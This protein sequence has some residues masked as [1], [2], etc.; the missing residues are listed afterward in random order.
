MA[1]C[2]RSARLLVAT[3]TVLAITGSGT[4][5][6]Q[7]QLRNNVSDF[8]INSSS[9]LIPVLEEV[10]QYITN[11]SGGY[12]RLHVASGQYKL[13]GPTY[14]ALAT[15]VNVSYISI[16]GAGVDATS[17]D[18]G[19]VAG[20]A[21]LDVHFVTITNLTFANC[22][23][24]QNSTTTN[25]SQSGSESGSLSFVKFSVALYMLDC[26]H[27]HMENVNI[28]N[29]KSVGLAMFNVYGS[30]FFRGC[31]FT[32]HVPPD[33]DR[34]SGS[35]NR[36]GGGGAII[37]FSFC[38]PGDK[39]C[40]ITSPV[41]VADAS[42]EFTNCEFTSNNASSLG[43]SP[44]SIYP[45]GLQHSGFGKGGGLAVYFRG[46]AINNSVTLVNCHISFNTAESSMG[47]GLYVEFG[48]QS[49]GNSFTLTGKDDGISRMDNNG[50]LCATPS[51][52]QSS[53]Q[54]NGGGGAKIVFMYYPPD[55][56]LWP[57]YHAN[58]TDNHV[59]FRDT[60]VSSNMACYGGGVAFVSSRADPGTHQTNTVHFS[61]CS[62][63]G[64]Q[65]V[66][67]A[68]LDISVLYPDTATHG[69]LMTPLIEQCEFQQNED[70]TRSDDSIPDLAGYQFGNGAL[71]I[72]TVP[73]NFSGVNRFTRNEGT[74]LVV[75]GANVAVTTN[76]SVLFEGN[77]GRRGGGLVVLGGGALVMYPGSH[78]NFSHNQA[79]ELGGAV[80]S[81]GQFGERYNMYKEECFIRYY[82]ST[83]LPTSWNTSFSFLNNSAAGV[84]GNS[85]IHVTSL[86]PCAWPVGSSPVA[87]VR[88][89]L[90]WQGWVY[91]NQNAETM[92]SCSAYITTAPAGFN[93]SRTNLIYQVSVYPG[94][95]HPIPVR[96]KDDYG[97]IVS[98]VVYQLSSRNLT[99]VEVPDKSIYVTN[100][101]ILVYGI[102]NSAK[103]QDLFLETLGPR[104][105]S[106]MLKV[107]ILPCPPGYAPQKNESAM[108]TRCKCG[109]HL[110]LTCNIPAMT[111]HI[112]P[113]YCFSY[114]TNNSSHTG[115][116]LTRSESTQH[117]R[118][119]VVQCPA[120]VRESKPMEL[121]V[122]NGSCDIEMKFCEGIRRNGTF[123]SGCVTG[124]AVDVN[125]IHDCVKCSNNEYHYG[126]F[127]YILTNIVPIT[128]FFIVVALFK[129]SATSAPMYAF[130]FFAQIA[131]VRYFHNQF[132]WIFGLSE[133]RSYLQSLF[134]CLYAIW[135]L[136]FFVFKGVICLSP[137]LTIMYS[138][139][140]K[141]LLALYPML[142]ILLSYICI[143]LY[144][145]NVMLIV[146]L[147]KPFRACLNKF[148]QSWQ[149]RTSI[150]DAFAAFLMIS[151]TKI[152]FIT[153]SLLTPAQEYYVY[154][155]RRSEV[156]DGYVFYFDPQYHYFQGQHLLFGLVALV[157]GVVFVLAPPVFLILY[158]TRVFQRC[159]N[160][161]SSR[162]SWQ[163][164]HTFADAFQGC[165]KNRSNNNRDYR[166]FSGLYLV[167]RIVI[168][169]IYAVESLPYLQ[170]LL[171]QIICV[172]A[173][174]LFALV[175]PYKEAFY[176]KVDLTF[177][178]LFS[179]M[180]SLSFANYTYGCFNDNKVN[181]VLF[182][183]NYALGYLPLLY[184]TVYVVYLL[185]KW[186]GVI[187]VDPVVREL[188]MGKSSTSLISEDDSSSADVP[189]RLLH[190]ENYTVTPPPS[191]KSSSGTLSSPDPINEEERERVLINRG[192][193]KQRA[194]E[195]SY[196][197][198]KAQYMKNY[199]SM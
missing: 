42:F 60:Y 148:R 140:L 14:T 15:F 150:I 23:S 39:Q 194:T 169:I 103:K 157:I 165:F 145:R 47:G 183:I 177:F 135:N 176:N 2:T 28:A 80:Y 24:L 87:D 90:C 12:F 122:C 36:H 74:G 6:E 32:N 97:N 129:I 156:P 5:S 125:D 151:Y 49:Q 27:V 162:C 170:L 111:A 65:A 43:L 22:S 117:T 75:S 126:W 7:T 134:L 116:F 21:F 172:L 139:L 118:M 119:I 120:T 83:V 191:H 121:P 93:N 95:S 89:A 195:G 144:D 133:K 19:G 197:L 152:A 33:T 112:L 185:L 76:T 114:S 146:W 45:H 149:P 141:Y 11:G 196:F 106:T 161:W 167:L 30:N 55:P 61:N 50:E 10:Q 175:K 158:P 82:K 86:L 26:S 109:Y 102:P 56:H 31:Q 94:H 160:R 115:S 70:N 110:Y 100:N 181:D 51:F 64:N 187:V 40:N 54:G 99:A 84:T 136:D 72:A 142:L 25:G 171:Q 199:S 71:Y 184:I 91:D 179:V 41:E 9:G 35:L 163:P 113:G 81:E 138:L 66:V 1:T 67:S 101:Q 62:F 137:D 20:F 174:L 154:H 147:W 68:A 63:F 178:S 53:I 37:E 34:A 96:V 13:G 52:G 127:I 188:T 85:T 107:T 18:G 132:P 180:N 155:D 78:L 164:V 4:C 190:P 17:I 73:T 189:D 58:V 159:L 153:I 88:R 38:T 198:R 92:E 168:L 16:A 166:Y 59:E 143:E 29:S 48:D 130:V 124:Y 77:S 108:V 182:G 186:R 104:I 105:L 192:R 46:R 128:I 44:V 79:L 98:S 3:W 69:E 193:P 57:G 173:V 8:Y 131:T 123:C